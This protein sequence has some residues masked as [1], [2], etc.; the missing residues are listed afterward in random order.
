MARCHYCEEKATERCGIC[1]LAICE[2]HK[3]AVNRWHNVFHARWICEGCYQAKER[4]RKYVLAPVLVVF[5]F[6]IARSMKVEWGL[7]EPTTWGYFLALASVALGVLGAAAVYHGI[8]RSKKFK[9]WLYRL[10]GAAALWSAL[11]LI[12]RGMCG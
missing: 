2:T 7:R 11:Y 12:Y 3:H 5:A 10:L 9:T 6:L 8:T 4:K 1:G